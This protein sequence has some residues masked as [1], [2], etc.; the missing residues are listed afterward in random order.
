MEGFSDLGLKKK[1]PV[2]LHVPLDQ[3][4]LNFHRN[5]RN[6]INFIGDIIF[7]VI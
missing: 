6:Q 5:E 2:S 3:I 1:N 7:H 4:E